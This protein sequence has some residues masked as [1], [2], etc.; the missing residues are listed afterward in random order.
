MSSQ[1]S[2]KI[3]FSG[4]IEYTQ[5]PYDKETDIYCMASLQAP[6]Y[7]TEE[8]QARSGLDLICVID[9]S[10][11]MAG[12]KIDLVRKTL[13]FMVEQLKDNDR[14]ALVEFDSNVSTSL[15]LVNMN[16]QGKKQAKKSIEA[17][18]AGSCTNLSGG[19]FAGLDIIAN[20]QKPNEITSVLLF[21][22]G[23]ANEGI[24]TTTEIVQKMEKYIHSEIKQNLSVFCF[25]F[26]ND[27]DANM[28]TSI[29]QAGSGLYYF[30][31]SVDEIP[32]SFG[33]VLGGLVS[34]IG[35]TIK[36]KLE[37]NQNVKLKKV[38]TTFRKQD[39][40]GGVGSEI[41]IGDIYSEEKKDIV[42]VLTLP[43][44]SSPIEQQQLC[45]VSLNYFNVIETELQS[46]SF[47]VVVDRSTNVVPSKQ[48][49]NVKLDVQRNRVE[50]GEALEQGRKLAD[51]N[52]L[53]EGRKVI[54]DAI[55]KI[56]QSVSAN[57]EFC[58]G[59][60]LDLKQCLDNMVDHTSY[61][62]VGS[63][64]MNNY[65]QANMQQRST[66][67]ESSVSQKL[68]RNKKK[69]SMANKFSENM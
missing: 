55:T 48:C 39:L 57:D 64:M 43:A 25:G 10:G 30:V 52:K 62:N 60:I 13:S 33:D 37:P 4:A 32:K 63:K 6:E 27:V 42:F 3:F 35:Q 16:E 50:A 45:K 23:L 1:Q 24:T 20:R 12:S 38:F 51:E 18:R 28:L 40:E 9:K 29:A 66:H 14:I 2:T 17:I 21:T 59:L 15:Q 67:S 56:E 19:L 44:L 36:V 69:V 58:Q 61:L 11:S 46:A 5:A 49:A 26:G 8:R 54:T 31:R 47:D 7:E 68:M 34:V 22:D 41:Q 65:W 53:V